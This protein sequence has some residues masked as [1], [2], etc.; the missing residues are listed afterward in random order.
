MW[1]LQPSHALQMFQET[2][3]RP[4]TDLSI[5]SL[6]LPR[7]PRVFISSH[8]HPPGTAKDRVESRQCYCT[9]RQ[10]CNTLACR[11]S[12][13]LRSTGA[14]RT[15]Q[16]RNLW[17]VRSRPRHLGHERRPHADNNHDTILG[18]SRIRLSR[19]RS[20]AWPWRRFAPGLPVQTARRS[21]EGLGRRWL[22]LTSYAL[23]PISFIM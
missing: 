6:S 12:Q 17:D 1:Y 5:V 9:A 3:F 4:H 11:P 15:G 22:I 16:V 2:L 23:P 8:C 14:R 10:P 21:V 20:W 18:G 19:C 13:T 7:F